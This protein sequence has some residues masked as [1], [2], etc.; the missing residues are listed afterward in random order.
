MTDIDAA[1]ERMLAAREGQIVRELGG[2]RLSDAGL[3]TANRGEPGAGVEVERGECVRERMLAN[4]HALEP[5]L[6]QCTCAFDGEVDAGGHIGEA[7]TE[8]VQHV[9]ANGVGVRNQK[10]AVVDAVNIVGQKRICNIGGNVLA[11]KA[12]INRLF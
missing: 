10:T 8:F 3:V 7:I 5:K 2:L 4:V 6:L 1:L 12:P 11:A 9:P